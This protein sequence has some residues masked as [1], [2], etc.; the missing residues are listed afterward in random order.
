[1]EAGIVSATDP[2][3]DPRRRCPAGPA[4]TRSVTIQAEPGAG[5]FL[6]PIPAPECGSRGL[7]KLGLDPSVGMHT[8]LASTESVAGASVPEPLRDLARD[9]GTRLQHDLVA[10]HVGMAKEPGHCAME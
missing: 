8:R 9:H 7:V 3:P 2:Q 4:L 10:G 1:M 6:H 5:V